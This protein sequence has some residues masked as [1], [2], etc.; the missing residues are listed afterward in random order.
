ME[1]QGFLSRLKSS[2]AD[3]T[4]KRM[5]IGLG[6]VVV[7]AVAW[8]ALSTPEPAVNPST[9]AA[10]PRGDTIQGGNQ[11]PPAYDEALSTA[12]SQR[13]DAA[14]QQGGSAM[15]T[16][17]AARQDQIVPVLDLDPPQEEAPAVELPVVQQPVIVQQPLTPAVPVVQPVRPIAPAADARIM[18]DA[19]FALRRGY[20]VAEVIPLSNGEVAT[21]AAEQT[22]PVPVAGGQE[23]PASKVNIPL[24]GTILYAQLESRANSDAPGPVL[25]RI[26][27]G[28][29]EGATLIGSF[30]TVQNALVISF[31][32]MTV[33][34]TRDGEEVNETVPISAVAVDTKH[35]G[36]ALATS[37]DRHL[38]QKLAIGF[39]ASFAKGF[40]SALAGNGRTRVIN[41]DGSVVETNPIL[42]TQEQLLA[43][44]GEAIGEAGRILMDE[45]GRRPTTVIV[46][47][48][49]AIGVLFL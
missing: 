47:G 29:L 24:A 43:A 15:P 17:R 1:K 40:G 49:T 11:V 9:V 44:G 4:S 27:Q 28:Q 3:S 14:R 21:P 32:R 23:A 35:I 30:Q 26:L 45:F 2:T 7:G 10:P 31:D 37:V 6:V 20:P 16:V 34:R 8:S 38:F 36:T 33:R 12:D 19:L 22:A 46:E 25:A 5:L 41:S 13:I 48:G 18:Q 39:T 42:D